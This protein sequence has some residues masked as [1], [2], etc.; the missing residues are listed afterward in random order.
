MFPTSP[1][2]NCNALDPAVTLTQDETTK[3]RPCCL[4]NSISVAF[5]STTLHFNCN[6]YEQDVDSVIPHEA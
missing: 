2:K 1:L 3:S 6:S 5:M 4:S